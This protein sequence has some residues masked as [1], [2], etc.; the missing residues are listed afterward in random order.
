MPSPSRRK[1]ERDVR[2]RFRY[3]V[4]VHAGNDK[5][6]HV[7]AAQTIDDAFMPNAVLR[8]RP[9]G[10]RLLTV[11]LTKTGLMRSE[12]LRPG[13]TCPSCPIMSGEPMLQCML[14]FTTRSRASRSKTSAV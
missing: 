12:M 7:G 4:H 10:V 11:S 2:C 9:A 14:C 13:A 6:I 1:P 3:D 8:L 5:T